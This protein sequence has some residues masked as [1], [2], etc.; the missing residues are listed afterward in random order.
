MKKL[1]VLILMTLCICAL[2]VSCNKSTY[3]DEEETTPQ[4]NVDNNIAMLVSELNKYETVDE[5]MKNESTPVDHKELIAE[6]NKITEQGFCSLTLK[7]GG[8]KAGVL[9]AEIAMKNNELFAKAVVDGETTGINASITKDNLL[10]YAVWSEDDNGNVK[11][12]DS[13]AIDLEALFEA[14]NASLEENVSVNINAEDMPIDPKELKMPTVTKE[15]ITYKDGKYI[16]NNDFLYDA[17]IETVDTVIDEMKNNGEEL[18]KDFEEQ[19]NEI[20]KEGK[21]VL[22]T[23][24]FELYFLAKLE[25]IEGMGMSL[26]VNASKISDALEIDKDEF[27]DMEQ[28]KIAF[29]VSVNGIDFVMEYEMPD[30]TL[31][32]LKLDCDY[33]Y[34]G[35]N[36][37]GF[38]LKYELE[39]TTKTSDVSRN[40]NDYGYEYHK[41]EIESY[42]KQSIEIKFDKSN[43]EKSDATVLDFKVSIE[44]YADTY[45]EYGNEVG[46]VDANKNKSESNMIWDISIKTTQSHKADISMNMNMAQVEMNNG[47]E[48]RDDTKISIEGTIEVNTE[49]V[50]LPEINE[51]V[52]AA[53]EK[54]LKN[55]IDD[56]DQ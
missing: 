48:V 46:M 1:F 38:E 11:V 42:D 15:H 13:Q 41:N 47:K 30:N 28:F 7:E 54:A 12:A 49:G 20:K 50:K 56:F 32:M 18:P 14:F 10:A 43:F 24:D 29:E 35:K 44:S 3:N 6:L 45:Y 21:K 27:G 17:F 19:Y 5:L 33:I 8:K 4:D 9:D 52:K 31:N 36:L 34:K 25:A 26:V 37:C 40:D 39:N 55:P 16:L 23:I 22:D 51:D 2:L 53:M